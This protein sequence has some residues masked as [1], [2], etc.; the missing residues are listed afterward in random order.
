LQAAPGNHTLLYE[1]DRVRVL[2]T[3]IA[4]GHTVPLHT[5]CQPG[6]LYILNF[7]DLFRR[8]AA[9]L[10][11]VDSRKLPRPTEG[12][13]LWTEPLAPHTLENVGETDLHVISVEVKS[14]K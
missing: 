13:E 1:N 11:L 2:D 7:S 4:P 10:V 12:I 8:D 9:G 6:A 3:N 14:A 5:H